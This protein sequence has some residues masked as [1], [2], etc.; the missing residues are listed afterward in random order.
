[1]VRY[2]ITENMLFTGS[3]ASYGL[4]TLAERRAQHH[5]VLMYRLK[6]DRDY[7]DAYRPL[8]TLHNNNKIRFK[9]RT[10]RLTTVLKSPFYC[11]FASG[12]I[13]LKKPKKQQ[14]RLNSRR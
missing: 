6:Q 12:I 4:H 10:T 8:I 2:T 9:T 7:I 1:M 14:L 3:L 13:Y 5:L 11:G